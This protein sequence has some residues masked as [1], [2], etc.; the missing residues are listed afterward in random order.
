MLFLTYHSHRKKYMGIVDLSATEKVNTSLNLL[1]RV[2]HI[3]QEDKRFIKV[4]PNLV[5]VKNYSSGIM[6]TADV[7]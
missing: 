7:D 2:K 3:L 5:G 1:R 6:Q 4:S